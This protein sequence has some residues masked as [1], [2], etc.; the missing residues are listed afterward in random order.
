MSENKEIKKEVYATIMRIQQFFDE[1]FPDYTIKRLEYALKLLNNEKIYQVD[2]WN[3]FCRVFEIPDKFP[4]GYCFGGGVDT[5]FKMVD[6]FY[7]ISDLGIAGCSKEEWEKK[8]GPAPFVEVSLKELE[9]EL[10]PFISKKEYIKLN[11]SYII[12]YSFG[13]VSY[14][15]FKE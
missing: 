11:K 13:A 6:W 9:K 2:P 4:S 3:N 10:L 14:L 7:P 5:T 1:E 15:D 8:I 12:I